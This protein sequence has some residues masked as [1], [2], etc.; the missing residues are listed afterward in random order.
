MSR[1]DF[2]KGRTAIAA[3][4]RRRGASGVGTDTSLVG[5]R[6]TEITEKTITACFFVIGIAHRR[7]GNATRNA[8]LKD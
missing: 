6:A 1:Y 4:A 8:E 2:E 5:H 3:K 7:H